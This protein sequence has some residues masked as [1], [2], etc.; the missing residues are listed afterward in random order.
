MMSMATRTAQATW[1]D[2]MAVSCPGSWSPFRSGR[3]DVTWVVST[4]PSSGRRRGGATGI[5]W[6]GTVSIAVEMTSIRRH[7]RYIGRCQKNAHAK[8]SSKP[9]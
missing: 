3:S 4:S 8:Q 9:V 7:H 6:N 2:G 1:T 5:D